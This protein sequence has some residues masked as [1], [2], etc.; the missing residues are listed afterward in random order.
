MYLSDHK[1]DIPVDM[2]SIKSYLGTKE[3]SDAVFARLM[4]N[5]QSP[6]QKPGYIYVKPNVDKIAKIEMPSTRLVIYENFD[7]W[8]GKI[9]VGFADGH[10]E[11]VVDKARFDKLVVEAGGKP[12]EDKKP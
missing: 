5:P 10:V 8:P 1:G 6:N 3:T 12:V 7:K 11:N 2:E 9:A 4:I